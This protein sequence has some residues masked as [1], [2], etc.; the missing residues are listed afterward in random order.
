MENK[1]IK[2]VF[3]VISLI[4]LVIAILFLGYAFTHPEFG[5]VF[6][7]GKVEISSSVW[8]LLYAV[9]LAVTV[10]LFVGSFWVKTKS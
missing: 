3:R 4:M 1:L 9:Y 2:I 5:S 10:G 7:I 8:R 6:Y